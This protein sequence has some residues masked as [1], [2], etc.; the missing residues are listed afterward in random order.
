MHNINKN[1]NLLLISPLLA[2]AGLFV[3]AYVR[4]YTLK[5]AKHGSTVYS[6]EPNL[7]SFKVL[8]LNVLGNIFDNNVKLYNVVFGNKECEVF[9]STNF[10]ET[11]VLP[12]L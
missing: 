7:Y 1:K 12:N 5:A 6:F 9:I 3:K 4:T 10:D 2:S 11:H 8:S